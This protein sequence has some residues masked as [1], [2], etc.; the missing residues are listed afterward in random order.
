L[1]PDDHHMDEV[2][3][4]CI[5]EAILTTLCSSME[6]KD[7]RGELQSIRG[8]G[9]FLSSM[10]G[11][12][13]DALQR[14]ATTVNPA[15]SSTTPATPHDSMHAS[16]ARIVE[17]LQAIAWEKL[18]LGAWNQV[19]AAWRDV[20][21]VACILAAV[22][23]VRCCHAQN[24]ESE[25]NKDQHRPSDEAHGDQNTTP[26]SP[27]TPLSLVSPPF[28]AAM[29]E[30]DKAVIMGGPAFR[31]LV[32]AFIESI[33]TDAGFVAAAAQAASQADDSEALPGP[34]LLSSREE[35]MISAARSAA[36]LGLSPS[37]H[38]AMVGSLPAGSLGPRG[39]GVEELSSLP[40]LDEFAARWLGKTPVV[41]EKAIE[42]WPAMRRW[43]SAA[44]W[45]AVAGPRLVPVEVG[46]HYLAEGWGQRL[47]LFSEFLER[48]VLKLEPE[49]RREG[50]TSAL[51]GSV[52]SGADVTRVQTA[53][54]LPHDSTQETATTDV[55]DAALAALNPP[56]HYLAQHALL[57]QIPALQRDILEPDYCVLGNSGV[58][59]VNAWLGPEGTTTP[60]HTDPHHNMLC[61]VVGMKYVR[62]YPPSSTPALY[63]HRGMKCNSSRVDVD[64]LTWNELAQRFPRFTDEPFVDCV[65]TPGQALY[66][67]QGWWH[68]VKSITTSVSVSFWWD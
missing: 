59:A 65:L 30:L 17:S 5:Q 42:G 60:L 45:N 61:Q 55:A 66:I 47:M 49:N 35:S 16:C 6:L 34:P 48:H 12:A 51:S 11:H 64:T 44:Y 58:Q 3:G 41:L 57:D 43:R 67:P 19:H 62:L 36:S 54:L 4:T 23:H 63:P 24:G 50:E 46:K 22:L 21:S 68:Y 33:L 14:S 32:D 28:A 9:P 26:P 53:R 13:L 8:G 37:S 1:L 7:L 56:V 29:E 20:Y 31:F 18:H 52:D 38:D 27:H 15:V 39:S 40:P 25:D 2:S 10:L